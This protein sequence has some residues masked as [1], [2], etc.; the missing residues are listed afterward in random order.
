MAGLGR[1]SLAE[2]MGKKGA[3]KGAS[4]SLDDLPQ[5]L[6]DALPELEFTQV[7]KS[8]LRRALQ[9]RFGDGFR[10]IPG[11]RNILKEFDARS[12]DFETIAKVKGIGKS[13]AHRLGAKET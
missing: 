11:V 7:G 12:T 4:L 3:Q 2:I 10:N 8:R 6:G 9:Q 1:A 5:L 13:V